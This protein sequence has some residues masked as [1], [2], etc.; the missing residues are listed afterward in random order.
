MNSKPKTYVYTREKTRKHLSMP[1]KRLRIGT[2]TVRTA[3]CATH[4]KNAVFAGV[5]DTGWLMT[6][7]GSPHPGGDPAHS[8]VASPPDA[9]PR[10]EETR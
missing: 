10:T 6:C 5:L 9:D 8:F 3:R 2:E 7:P 1:D 4:N